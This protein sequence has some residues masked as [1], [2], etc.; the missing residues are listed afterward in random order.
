MN[1]PP[2]KPK[3]RSLAD[4]RI[5][6]DL[7]AMVEEARLDYSQASSATPR[8]LAQKDIAARFHRVR[9]PDKTPDE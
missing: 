3:V 6:Y 2:P 9:R 1:T 4:Y 7:A 8:L 5:H